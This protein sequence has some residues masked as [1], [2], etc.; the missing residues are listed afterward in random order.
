M[1][2]AGAVV[3][4]GGRS[5]RM[6]RP[7]ALLDWNGRTAV[8]HAVAVAR[9]GVDGGTVCVVRAP[10]QELP[11]LEAVVVEDPV[12]FA[13]PLA[14]LTEGLAALEGRCEVAF[15]CG[16]DTPLLVPELVQVVVGALQDEDDAVVPVADGRDQPLLA[17]YRVGLAARLRELLDA[18][19]RSLRD[20]PNSCSVRRLPEE[21]FRA[22][23]PGLRSAV[24]ANTPEE[25]AA[26]LDEAR[27]SG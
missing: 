16:V 11:D 12:A 20:I 9:A 25:W 7:K 14:A 21:A 13:G 2:R 15:A 19:H 27:A 23:D 1:I 18:G 3:L 22:V 4:A 5:S 10:G 8:E 24:N 17:A 26:L 6:G